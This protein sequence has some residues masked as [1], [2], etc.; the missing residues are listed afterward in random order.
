MNELWMEKILF[1]SIGQT[2]RVSF[3]FTRAS[4]HLGVIV[5]R[6]PFR[7]RRTISPTTTSLSRG[8]ID[9]MTKCRKKEDTTIFCSICANFCPI[10]FRGP[11]NC[12]QGQNKFIIIKI[13]IKIR[14]RENKKMILVRKSWHTFYWKSSQK[15]TRL[16]DQIVENSEMKFP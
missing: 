12:G 2:F 9:L 3:A 13:A 15:V 4:R 11:V 10:Q 1:V 6:S 16:C 8:S 14:K 5:T 7:G